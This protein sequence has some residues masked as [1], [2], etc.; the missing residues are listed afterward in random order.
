MIYYWWSINRNAKTFLISN[1]MKA[2][3]AQKIIK[4]SRESY[5]KIAKQFSASRTHFWPELNFIAEL[6]PPE[7][8]ILDVGCGNG[9]LLHILQNSRLQYTGVD[10]AQALLNEAKN[11]YPEKNFILADALALPFADET[12]DAVVS[13]AVLHHIPS[14]ELR[15]KFFFEAARVLKPG[16]IMIITVWNFWRWRW[17]KELIASLLSKIIHPRTSDLGDM[18]MTFGPLKTPRYLH[19]IT[20]HE[21]SSLAAAFNLETK[22]ISTI[23]SPDGNRSNLLLIARKV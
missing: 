16:G 23:N 21:L 22:T 1:G 19:A 2:E 4:E 13:L 9:R 3:I 15:N 17:I 7:G 12:F 20:K 10:S 11:L 18:N 8:S 6:L 14:K 5:D